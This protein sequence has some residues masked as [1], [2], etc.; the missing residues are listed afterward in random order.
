[1]TKTNITR[2]NTTKKIVI[3]DTIYEET[4]NTL[5]IS[6]TESSGSLKFNA[7]DI[8]NNMAEGMANFILENAN[9]PTDVLKNLL[10]IH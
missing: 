1:M 2:T 4:N 9:L 10:A 8:D 6:Y 5:T 7:E 3:N